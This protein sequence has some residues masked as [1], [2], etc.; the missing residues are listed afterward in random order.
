MMDVRAAIAASNV[1]NSSAGR[2]I[3]AENRTDVGARRGQQPQAILFGL[4]KG[5][6]VRQNPAAA[7]WFETHAR[8]D[9]GAAQ[10]LT[11]NL[12]ALRVME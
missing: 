3:E 6:L 2:W 11:A 8:D 5:L 4:G 10:R 1:R 9:P 12:E 7:E